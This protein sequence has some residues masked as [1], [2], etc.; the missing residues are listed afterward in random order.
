LDTGLDGVEPVAVVLEKFQ[1]EVPGEVLAVDAKGHDLPG[2]AK[3]KGTEDDFNRI[4]HF[5]VNFR[6]LGLG[7]KIRRR[8]LR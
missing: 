6:E 7:T 2:V 8:A 3:V 4:F 5:Y 1:Q